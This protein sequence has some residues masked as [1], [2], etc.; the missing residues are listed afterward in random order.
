[1]RSFSRVLGMAA[2]V[3]LLVANATYAIA[4]GESPVFQAISAGLAAFALVVAVYVL[5]HER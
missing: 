1:M 3:G 2:L 4:R 5:M